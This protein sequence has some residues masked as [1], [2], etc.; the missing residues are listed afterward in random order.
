MGELEDLVVDE[1]DLN[2]EI[3]RETLEPYIRIGSETGSLIPE[4]E[5]ADLTAEDKILVS[6]LAFKAMADIGIRETERIGPKALAEAV[7]ISEG[8]VYPTV[9]KLEDE[10]LLTKEDGKYWV[11]N[12]KIRRIQERLEFDEQS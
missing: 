1:R 6:T 5:L 4:P 3:L 8:T 10:G 7:G 11:P 2:Q 12:H 9:R